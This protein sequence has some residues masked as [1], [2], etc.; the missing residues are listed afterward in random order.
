MKVV[1]DICY[2]EEME[3]L[4]VTAVKP[5]CD[6]MML[7]TFSNGEKRLFDTTT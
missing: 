1:D 3:N 5:L 2:G 7:V 4:E 6:G